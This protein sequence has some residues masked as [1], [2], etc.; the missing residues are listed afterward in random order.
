MTVRRLT[1]SDLGTVRDL[2]SVFAAAFEDKTTYLGSPPS[3]SYVADLL[4][5]EKSIV[6]A[7]FAEAAVVG[8][9]IAYELKKF[10]QER[11]E[12]YI[13]DLAV[14]E[15][16]RRRGIASALISHLKPIAKQRNAW[17]IY[18]QADYVDPPAVALYSKLGAKEEVL[19]FDI[20]V[21]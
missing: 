16:Y 21:D 13:Y 19:H 5:D 18:V 6:L 1:A 9:L 7:A 4:T 3:D 12:I 10:E 8:G 14:L 15:P 20:A 11:S 17:A 2:M